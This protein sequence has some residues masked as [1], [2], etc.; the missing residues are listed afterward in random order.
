MACA[1]L[2]AI[3]LGSAAKNGGR[4]GLEGLLSRR[5]A[6]GCQSRYLNPRPKLDFHLC[7]ILGSWRTGGRQRV[8]AYWSHR[9]APSSGQG[10]NNISRHYLRIGGD[11]IVPDVW[12]ISETEAV[13]WGVSSPELGPGRYFRAT[14]R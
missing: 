3:C 6:V 2:T 8:R 10:G 4:L 7:P 12:R 1:S 11:G 14:W 9:R 13:R 5:P